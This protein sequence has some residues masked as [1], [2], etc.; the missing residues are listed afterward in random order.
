MF[1]LIVNRPAFLPYAINMTGVTEADATAEITVKQAEAGFITPL[2]LLN[3]E[4]RE[5][6]RVVR[7][8]DDVDTFVL[9]DNA[10]DQYGE[11][12]TADILMEQGDE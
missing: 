7:S 2:F 3:T 4:T 6:K 5:I 11:A 12:T 8:A 9:T 1:V 10:F